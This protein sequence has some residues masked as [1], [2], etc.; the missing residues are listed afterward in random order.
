MRS[1]VD[2]MMALTL[3]LLVL[4]GVILIRLI[5]GDRAESHAQQTTV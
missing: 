5:V 2:T 4:L 3:A 1:E